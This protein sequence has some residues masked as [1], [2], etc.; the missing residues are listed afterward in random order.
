[1]SK[2]QFGLRNVHIAPITE[3][4]QGNITYGTP[5]ALPGA[6]SLDLSP[7]G[8]ESVFYADD[9]RYYVIGAR[10]GY[11]GSMTIAMVTDKFAEDIL[12]YVKDSNNLLV[13]SGSLNPI[14][15]AMM[16]EVQT[17]TKNRKYVFY[18]VTV[19][20]ADLSAATIEETTEVQTATLEI[21][22]TSAKDTGYVR[23][24]TTEETPD[25][26]KD[27]WYTAVPTVNPVTSGGEDTPSGD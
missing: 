7:S 16:F 15:F 5:F 2:V 24:Y 6:V 18:N 9:M 19:T 8:S 25:A 1:M 10:A 23:A 14:P 27:A 21:S 13:E 3:D 26:V 11:S 20:S 22:V 4:A 12:K 17:D